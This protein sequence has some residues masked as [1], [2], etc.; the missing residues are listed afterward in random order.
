[1]FCEFGR[2]V[3]GRDFKNAVAFFF[4]LMEAQILIME[5]EKNKRQILIMELEKNKGG[6]RGRVIP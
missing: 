1:M 5:L 2:M 6:A 3:S 4:T